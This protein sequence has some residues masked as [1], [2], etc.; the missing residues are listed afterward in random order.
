MFFMKDIFLSFLSLVED[1]FQFEVFR[2]PYDGLPKTNSDFKVYKLPS[3]SG[4]Y[5]PYYVSFEERQDFKPFNCESETN[6][7]LT[8][9]F[10]VRMLHLRATGLDIKHTVH[11]DGYFIKLEIYV[12]KYSKG[13]RVIVFS[14]YYLKPKK[15][16]GFLV[17]VRFR[18]IE[19]FLGVD[20]DM[21]KLSF[22]LDKDGQ[23]NR[24]FYAH[25]Y[26]CLVSHLRQ[27][28]SDLNPIDF[29]KSHLS[30]NMTFARVPT[31]TLAKKQ[32]IFNGGNVDSSQYKGIRRFKPYKQLEGEC[33]FIFILEDRFK[34]FGNKLFLSLIGKQN[35][36]TFSGMHQTFGIDI[37]KAN[38]ERVS[39]L[40]TTKQELDSA[41][42]SV[43]KICD[44]N[45]HSRKIVVFI[46]KNCNVD[47]A[48]VS[49]TYY[50]LKYQFTKL[51]I[52]L[53]VLSYEKIS[54]EKTLKWS[55]SNIGLG[56][57]TK[58]GGVPWIVKPSTAN[59]LI[60]GI[61]SAHKKDDQ[62]NIER[63]FAYSVCLDSSGIYKKLEVLADDQSEESYLEALQRNLVAL[64]QGDE[65]E[66]Y[67]KCA[68][69]IPFKIKEKEIEAIESAILKVRQM[70]FKVLKI[71]VKNKFFGY[72][73]H[74][75]RT[76]YESSLV[77][78]NG[79][80]YLVWFEGLQMGQE[81]LNERI[82]P[83]VHVQFLNL[84][85]T[86]TESVD[87]YLQDLI[88]L[89]G[90]NWR[91]FNA[92]VK[93]ISIYYSSI[94]AKYCKAF[95]EFPDFRREILSLDTPWFL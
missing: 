28:L 81:V 9:F 19:S 14:P 34:N 33:C 5:I 56:L 20:M 54:I 1:N 61:G 90:T 40:N 83:P 21:L 84:D 32:Y 17:D 57:F 55:T 25:K 24:N 3:D 86:S 43:Q 39:I 44:K 50:Y 89:T 4:G 16:F 95:E 2:K 80:E 38:V 59:C 79:N 64:L 36:G 13:S 78:L 77:K 67:T 82:S 69:H 70:D 12:E 62:G 76:P 65:F 71:N 74:N 51:R 23:A 93:P 92:K 87:S 35:P 53:Q 58:L 85:G 26:N 66:K 45:P 49:D 52:P 63:F 46:E 8:Q 27:L 68:L 6:R 18:Q 31:Y 91:G 29:D 47:E 88:N 94:I 37:N 48:G 10:L 73:D 41:I 22:S 75:T 7:D 42:S 15:K 72:S 60:L 30:L 11:L